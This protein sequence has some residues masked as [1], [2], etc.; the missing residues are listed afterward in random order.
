MLDFISTDMEFECKDI[1]FLAHCLKLEAQYSSG[2]KKY[3]L[4][5]CEK[6]AIWINPVYHLLRI[7]GSVPYYWQGNNF[8][9]TRKGFTE[10]IEY[11]IRLLGVNIWN[12]TLN[13][14]EYGVIMEVKMPPKEYIMH[15]SSMPKEKL[16]MNEKP[17]DKGNF[18]TW[19][20]RNVK[21]KMYNAGRNIL[22]KQG[23][24]RKSIIRAAGWDDSKYYLKWEIHYLK[25]E[26]LNHGN[27]LKLYNLV[28]PDWDNTFKE[29]LFTQYKRLS[30]MKGI[31]NPTDKKEL[32]TADI[33]ILAMVEES[34]NEDRTLD[35]LRKMLYDKVNSFP[36]E[37]LKKPDKDFR[38]MQ[39][40]K[41][42]AKVKE[43][44]NSVFD[45]SEEIT[46]ALQADQ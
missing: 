28:N 27:G 42:L 7:E 33:L 10:A 5:G 41:L 16:L 24:N 3:Y 12:S 19:E 38:K 8:S 15:H 35:E 2:W 13:A 4:D 21:L 26:C 14:F 18:R 45:L 46:K 37:V 11:I 32:S 22:M 43:S 20:D 40:R 34:I 17:K 1:K 9:F 36:D 44:P 29:D 30:P 25:P 31:I 39:I 23:E 6:M